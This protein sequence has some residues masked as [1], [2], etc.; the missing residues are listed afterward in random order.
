MQNLQFTIFLPGASMYELAQE[1]IYCEQWHLLS[2]K[3]SDPEKFS[4]HGFI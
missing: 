4:P 2:H 3:L 1:A